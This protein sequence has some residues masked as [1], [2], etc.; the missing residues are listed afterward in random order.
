MNVSPFRRVV[1]SA[2]LASSAGLVALTWPMASDRTAQ[3][4]GQLPQF[5]SYW[6]DSALSANQHREFSM[7]PI[8]FVILS[9]VA[10]GSGTAEVM[11]HRQGR[12]QRQ[13]LCNQAMLAGDQQE[14]VGGARLSIANPINRAHSTDLAAASHDA[15]VVATTPKA[16]KTLD[17]VVLQ[18]THNANSQAKLISSPIDDHALYHIQGADQCRSLA[19][20]VEGEYYRY[21][22]N[23]PDLGKAQTLVQQ[24]HQQGKR[25]LATWDDNGYVVWVH[26]PERPQ[27][28]VPWLGRLATS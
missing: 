3:I 12:V 19:L 22:R 24:L 17:G 13:G 28:A 27:Q 20:A 18:A 2:L 23:R 16:A 10:I 25:A 6:L 4:S 11:R 26:Q 8:G 21:Y 14:E 7:R 9:S 5:L 1:L 15:A